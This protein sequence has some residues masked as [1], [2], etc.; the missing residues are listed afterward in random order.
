MDKDDNLVEDLDPGQHLSTFLALSQ[1][2]CHQRIVDGSLAKLTRTVDGLPIGGFSGLYQPTYNHN[3][4]SLLPSS[5]V[6]SDP[7]HGNN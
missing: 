7:K 5:Q 1:H 4:S 6:I 2:S 3:P